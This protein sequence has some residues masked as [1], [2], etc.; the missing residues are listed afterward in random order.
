MSDVRTPSPRMLGLLLEMG[1]TAESHPE[2]FASY[3]AAFAAIRA[4]MAARWGVPGTEAQVGA[5]KAQGAQLG[6]IGRDYP[7]APRMFLSMQIDICRALDALDA[8]HGPTRKVA[9]EMLLA[10]IRRHFTQFVPQGTDRRERGV[11]QDAKAVQA[12]EA[13]F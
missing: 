3:E 10:Q 13:P 9:G 1:M 11:R 12:E 8:A 5:V 7:G 6:W 4:N 2:T